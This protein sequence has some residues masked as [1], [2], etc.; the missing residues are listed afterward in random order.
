MAKSSL[1]SEQPSYLQTLDLY[2]QQLPRGIGLS[3][4]ILIIS[5]LAKQL[6]VF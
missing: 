4:G 1:L 6:F 5:Q 3:F 2:L